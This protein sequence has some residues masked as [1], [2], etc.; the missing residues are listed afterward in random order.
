ME[1]WDNLFDFDLTFPTD[2]DVIIPP[3]DDVN[4][5]SPPLS[6]DDIE[7]LLFK[8]DD[9][10]QLPTDA[11]L[12][13][14][15]LDSPLQEEKSGE[16]VDCSD[17]AEDQKIEE[18]KDD[19]DPLAKKRKRQL[20]NRDAAL[21]S[22]ERKKMHVKDLELKSRYYEGECKRLGSL[23]QWYMAENQALRFSLHSSSSSNASMTKQESAVLLLESLLLGSL[24]WLTGIMA[25]LPSLVLLLVLH[26]QS[27]SQ[28]VTMVE[29]KH[30]PSLALRKEEG[31]KTL[32]VG[33]RF[34]ASR[35]RMRRFL[36]AVSDILPVF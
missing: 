32:S 9:D 29:E 5:Q 33:K 34:K 2:D 23:L 28:R 4:N 3:D 31:T 16:V 13:D 35:S 20:R 10:A 19:D 26:H 8:D 12:D 6:V 7:Q 11:F 25:V 36:R 24:L 30:L 22:R 15:L 27:Q 21:R 14:I 17:S 18:E 1:D